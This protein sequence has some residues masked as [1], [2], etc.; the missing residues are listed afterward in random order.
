MA[1]RFI[2]DTE[3]RENHAQQIVGGKFAGDF[4]AR[5][6]GEAQVFGRKARFGCCCRGLR[7][8]A[9]LRLRAGR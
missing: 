2:A 1:N 5:V 3:A 8:P 6:L 4:A 9:Q 7:F